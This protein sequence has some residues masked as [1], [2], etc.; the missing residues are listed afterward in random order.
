MSKLNR[1]VGK[2]K[3]IDL[4]GVELTINSITLSNM[5]MLM[6][7]GNEEKRAGALKKMIN[8]V[9]LES[10]P[11]ATQEEIDS[12][13]LKYFA[14]IMEAINEV[15]GLDAGNAKQEFL[16]QIKEKQKPK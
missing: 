16:A 11:D 13:S 6:D 2:G 8:K 3:I 7:M 4:D 10:V 1:L 12:I 9:L 15:N 14:Q 5:D